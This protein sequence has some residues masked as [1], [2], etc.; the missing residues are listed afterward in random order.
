MIS[1]HFA[2]RPLVFAIILVLPDWVGLHSLF[3]GEPV[4][5]YA[6]T[7]TGPKSKGIYRFEFDSTTGTPGSLMLAAET[8][9][10]SFLALHPNGK[11]LYAVN[12][13]NE[14]KGEKGGALSAFAI[15]KEGTLSLLNQ[16]ST[17]GPGPC[18]LSV[19]SQG[20]VVIAA[21][22]SGGSVISYRLNP[23][24][25]I[26]S[27]GSFIQHTGSSVNRQR[28]EGP[29]A[30]GAYLDAKDRFVY[31]PDLGLDKIM[32]Y[33]LD[34]ARGDLKPNDPPAGILPPGSGPRHFALHPRL[35]FA[36]SINEL[37]STVTTFTVNNLTG[38]LD[39]VASVPALPGDFTGQS[40]TAEIFIHPNGR[41]LYGSNRGHDSIAVF[42]IDDST[43]RLT[44]V[45]HQPIGG[46][47]P[48]G[49]A[50]DPT[51]RWLLAAAQDS[52]VVNVFKIDAATGR[53][54]ST[55]G[56]IKVPAPVCLVFHAP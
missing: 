52:D 6:G 36:W 50:I 10:P 7:Y 39:A 49:F 30:H 8:P 27:R 46:R 24:G 48:R 33:R 38:A 51:G 43:G 18:H 56:T 32:I 17:G 16:A 55:P 9:S 4:S 19:D 42:A 2:L 53:L 41:F 34:G 1:P 25:R 15:G 47:A 13:V 40:S 31:V 14:F 20:K 45:Q 3:A 29:H 11:L 22:Y 44:L 5:V 37:L 28:Q 12:E 23:D 54:S 26:G 21:N 35:P